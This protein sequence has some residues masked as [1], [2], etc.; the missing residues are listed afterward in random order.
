M[1]VHPWNQSLWAQLTRDR[2]RL[3]H[4]L[5]LHGMAGVGKRQLGLALAE[6]LLCETPGPDGGCG[7]CRSCGW[8]AQGGHPDMRIVEPGEE[9]GEDEKGKRGRRLITVSQVREMLEFLALSAHQGGWRVVLLD[10]AEAMNTPAANALLKT[11]E[12][13]PARVMLILVSHQPRRLLPT[14]LSRCYKMA[15]PRPA[16][17]ASL[18]WLQAQSL[19]AAEELLREA[20]GA[21]LQALEYA[22]PERMQRRAQFAAAL[23]SPKEQD[24][25]DLAHGMQ[26]RV[27][28]SWGWLL[29]WVCDLICSV[30]G[31]PVRYFPEHAA[32]LGRLAANIQPA[33]LWALY[34]ELLAAGRWLHH[35]LNSQLLLESW[36]LQYASVEEYA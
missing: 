23:A 13:P 26:S 32:A 35:P 25:C 1:T 34:Q 24:W 9:E 19:R 11:L 7:Q 2:E 21:P 16:H 30:S 6:W 10:P 28:E 4:A 20:G 14:V 29:R 5:L 8:F 12:E 27:G 3:P 33:R 22:D 36:L 18:E 31:T 17:Q 15:V